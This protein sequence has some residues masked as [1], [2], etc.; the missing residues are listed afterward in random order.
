MARAM[1]S[2]PTSYK[3]N[4]FLDLP[5]TDNITGSPSQLPNRDHTHSTSSASASH[6]NQISREQ[7]WPIEGFSDLH[8]SASEPR[9]FPGLVSRRNT[10]RQ[11]SGSENDNPE[12]AMR[13]RTKTALG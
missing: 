5:E 12:F 8:I 3:T 4:R 11:G 13:S 10:V 9:I 6:L 7:S 2:N 1:V